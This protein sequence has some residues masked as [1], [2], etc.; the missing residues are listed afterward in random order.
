MKSCQI[1]FMLL[2]ALLSACSADTAGTEAAARRYFET[3]FKK[4]MAGEANAVE[5]LDSSIKLLKEPI[6]YEIKSVVRDEPRFDAAQEPSDLPHGWQKWPAFRL[7]VA[8]EW[9]SK[10]GTPR[11]TI[12]TY[13]LTWNASENRWYAS[14]RL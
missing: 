2:V 12:T 6:S 5:T 4:W 14:E 1:G 10:A 9:K 7:N 13:T 8:I 11:T 3:E